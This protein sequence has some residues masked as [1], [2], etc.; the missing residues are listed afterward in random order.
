MDKDTKSLAE[1][2]QPLFKLMS[3]EYNLILLESEMQD[4]MEAVDQVRVNL[5]N[6]TSEFNKFRDKLFK[7]SGRSEGLQE[8]MDAWENE[9]LKK[10]E[11]KI[12]SPE[13]NKGIKPVFINKKTQDALDQHM[14]EF[15]YAY[16]FGFHH[17]GGIEAWLNEGEITNKNYNTN[18]NKN[19]MEKNYTDEQ[20]NIIRNYY[21]H[22][23]DLGEDGEAINVKEQFPEMFEK[24]KIYL[25]ATIE[26]NYLI[27]AEDIKIAL[28]DTFGEEGYEF[29]VKYEQ[30]LYPEQDHLNDAKGYVMGNP[31]ASGGKMSPLLHQEDKE[32]LKEKKDNRAD[33]WLKKIKEKKDNREHLDLRIEWDK[34]IYELNGALIAKDV[35][36]S[37]ELK[38]PTLAKFLNYTVAVL[39]DPVWEGQTELDQEAEDSQIKEVED[40]FVFIVKVI[41]AT[42]S[43]SWY[44]DNIG[45][46]FNVT[47]CECRTKY[48]VMK[49]EKNKWVKTC[50][51]L[52]A[53][54]C[55]IM[56]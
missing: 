53:V 15:N 24:K 48:F 13:Y 7:D 55:E 45:E 21:D 27:S 10:W 16:N 50:L 3:N 38:F 11:N 17:R 29:D 52:K 35:L 51:R 47:Q 18:Q 6:F 19:K 12:F 22:C 25:R 8:R 56:G 2:Y 36:D 33:E 9:R 20:K 1:C 34:S 31:I 44:N 32:V 14:K 49:K 37:L 54:D 30:R 41:K 40:H 42:S 46:A 4:V 26:S 43:Q 23:I 5:N 28:D 39:P